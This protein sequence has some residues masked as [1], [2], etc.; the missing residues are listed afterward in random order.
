MG[1]H[2]APGPAVGAISLKGAEWGLGEWM[3]VILHPV[4]TPVVVHVFTPL[5]H[6]KHRYVK[7]RRNGFG[8]FRLCSLDGEDLHALKTLACGIQ[9]ARTCVPEIGP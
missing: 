1:Q 6:V 4:E 9:H 5:L 7:S 8:N 2:A 3:Q